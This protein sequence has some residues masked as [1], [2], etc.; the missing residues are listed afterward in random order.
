M[1]RYWPT[2][3]HYPGT[4]A[5]R[6]WQRDAYSSYQEA[7]WKAFADSYY[8]LAYGYSGTR[9]PR[10]GGTRDLSGFAAW[11]EKMV[12][13]WKNEADMRDART[14]G[15]DLEEIPESLQLYLYE[16]ML[17]AK[18]EESAAYSYC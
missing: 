14:R 5:H 7:L 18:P 13:A 1:A 15:L 3:P 11:R 16:R 9:M 10:P 17:E 8:S 6:Q 2:P 4:T 12:T